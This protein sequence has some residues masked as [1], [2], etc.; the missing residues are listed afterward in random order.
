MREQVE[1]GRR[2]LI[3]SVGMP[4]RLATLDLGVILLSDEIATDEVA[5]AG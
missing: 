1:F 5:L 2:F 3:Y 4:W